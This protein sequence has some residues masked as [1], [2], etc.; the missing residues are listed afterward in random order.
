MSRNKIHKKFAFI[1][2]DPHFHV[3][4]N[5]VDLM[6]YLAEQKWVCDKPKKSKKIYHINFI[7]I[8]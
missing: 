7:I 6:V 1:S 2:T 4:F 5:F 8:H 3:A